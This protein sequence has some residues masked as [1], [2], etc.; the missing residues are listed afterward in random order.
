MIKKEQNERKRG[1]VPVFIQPKLS[2]SRL[3]W[4][5]G[6]FTGITRGGKYPALTGS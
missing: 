1:L 2:Q 5:K 6:L 3:G 4:S